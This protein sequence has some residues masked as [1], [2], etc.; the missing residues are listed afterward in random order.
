[1]RRFTR[2]VLRT[3]VITLSIAAFAAVLFRVWILEPYRVPHSRMSPAILPGD[4]LLVWKP[5]YEWTKRL[6]SVGE[7]LLVSASD[8]EDSRRKIQLARVIAV[9]GPRIRVA[10]DAGPTLNR[11]ITPEEILGKAW[12]VWLSIEPRNADEPTA[13]KSW[14]SRLRTDRFFKKVES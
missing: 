8:T 10:D 11:E 12:R 6:P 14:F 4:T 3:Y 9:D 7:V 5:G 1:M 2:S 13:S